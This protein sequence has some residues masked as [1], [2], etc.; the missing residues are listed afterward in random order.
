LT[1]VELRRQGFTEGL[2]IVPDEVL[3]AAPVPPRSPELAPREPLAR[4]LEIF[5]LDG[6]RRDT[7]LAQPEWHVLARRGAA[8][9]ARARF[10]VTSVASRALFVTG[11]PPGVTGILGN[12]HFGGTKPDSLLS[13]AA[14]AGLE[15]TGADWVH[16]LGLATPEQGVSSGVSS[17]RRL[18]LEDWGE[19]DAAGHAD[20]AASAEYLAAAHECFARLVARVRAADLERDAILVLSDHGHV[21]AGGHL[22]LEPEVVSVPVLFLGAGVRPG[23][24]VDAPV[25]LEDVGATAALLLGVDPPELSRGVPVSAAIATPLDPAVERA[26]RARRD[27]LAR[28]WERAVNPRR[29]LLG[30]VLGATLLLGTF[31][32]VLRPRLAS[33]GGA[34]AL[35]GPI[36]GGALWAA[37]GPPICNSA[38][39]RF[40]LGCAFVGALAGAAS[41]SAAI[42]LRVAPATFA[43]D[44]LAAWL[45]PVAGLLV[46]FGLGPG[47]LEPS[48]EAFWLILAAGSLSCVC[49]LV[50]FAA[51]V[52]RTRA[53]ADSRSPSIR[54][55][56]RGSM[57]S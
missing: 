13:R 18:L 44:A 5:V 57:S 16:W 25:G 40:V 38:D 12:G 39:P 20:G 8:L 27:A 23:V 52:S 22:G 15:I 32:T 46:R 50:L 54:A 1:P 49:L 37:V 4:D 28:S 26:Y 24:T 42:A 7:A 31:L 36:L 34:A 43:R 19:C 33:W 14:S 41:V 51:A 10:P 56:S 9:E 2:S 53:R 30:R 45:F 3:P 47:G 21:D 55:A 17:S 29:L 6:L 48:Q 35:I 11:A